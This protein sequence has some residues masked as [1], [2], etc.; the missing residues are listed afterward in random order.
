[1][2]R[3]QDRGQVR[4]IVDRSQFQH[5]LET[6]TSLPVLVDWRNGVIHTKDKV[7]GEMLGALLIPPGLPEVAVGVN[8]LN[9]I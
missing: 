9:H 2:E 5:K 8:G 3:F 1:M 6:G 4:R 7:T